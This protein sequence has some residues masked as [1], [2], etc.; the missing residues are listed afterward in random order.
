M[1][2]T[3]DFFFQVKIL[4]TSYEK[5]TF[6]NS[7]LKTP[8]EPYFSKNIFQILD[9]DNSRWTTSRTKYPYKITGHCTVTSVNEKQMYTTGGWSDNGSDSMYS[10]HRLSIENNVF[11][12]SWQAM[13]SMRNARSTHACLAT[14]YK[15]SSFFTV[16]FRYSALRKR[17]YGLSSSCTTFN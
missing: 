7:S 17:F 4:W 8:F 13:P 5:F 10:F 6:K 14:R 3:P 1:L 2:F 12:K 11:G 15:V 9:L 16:S